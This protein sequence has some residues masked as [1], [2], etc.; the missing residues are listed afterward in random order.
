MS[1]KDLIGHGKANAAAEQAE[2]KSASKEEAQPTFSEPAE[3][4]AP[5]QP[6]EPLDAYDDVSLAEIKH[7][8]DTKVKALETSAHLQAG[9]AERLE[10]IAA[11][12]NDLYRQELSR[13]RPPV[14]PKVVVPLIV[15]TLATSILSA[16]LVIIALFILSRI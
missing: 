11:T 9:T 16:L 5:P 12:L 1:Y 15:S 2:R 4:T 3:Q 7:E 14:A 8:L 6:N 13:K 10:R